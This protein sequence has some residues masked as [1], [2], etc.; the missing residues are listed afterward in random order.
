MTDTSSPGGFIKDHVYLAGYRMIRSHL[1]ARPG[2]HDLLMRSKWPLHRLELLRNAGIAENLG[3]EFRRPERA[4]MDR[5][6]TVV[7]ERLL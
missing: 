4:F 3:S 2:D 5:V 6:T 1:K 7:R